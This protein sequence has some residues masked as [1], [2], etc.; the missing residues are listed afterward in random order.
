MS[1]FRESD[2][3][4]FKLK[5]K[6]ICGWVEEVLPDKLVLRSFAQGIRYV[7]EKS[8][9]ERLKP[10]YIGRDEYR[11]LVR[12]ETT[13]YGTDNDNAPENIINKDGYVPTLDDLCYVL[14]KIVQ[15]KKSPNAVKREWLVYFLGAFHVNENVPEDNFFYNYSTVLVK[16]KSD[17]VGWAYS[18]KEIDICAIIDSIEEYQKNRNLP[19]FE[20]QYPEDV[21][22]NLLRRLD[23][24][25]SLNAVD[26]TT[27]KLYKEFAQELCK[28]GNRDGLLAVGYGCYGGNRAFPCDWKKAEECML[29]L[30]ETVD[31]MPARAYYANTLGYIYYYGR[32]NNG[33]PEYE[34]AYK[35]FSYAA[36]NRLIEAEYKIADM[37]QNGYGVQKCL[38]TAKD[39][40]KCLYNTL[41]YKIKD[42]RVGS[43]FADVAL[44]MSRFCAGDCFDENWDYYALLK[45]CYQAE[46]AIRLRRKEFNYY[47][48]DAVQKNIFA[49]LESAKSRSEFKPETK[50][51]CDIKEFFNSFISGE[52]PLDIKPQKMAY[53]KYKLKISSHKKANSHSK[54]LFVTIPELDVCGFYDSITVMLVSSPIDGSDIPDEPFTIDEIDDDAWWDDGSLKALINFGC[55]FEIRKPKENN[56]KYRFVIAQIE[57]DGSSRKCLCDDESIKVGDLVDVLFY[58]HT[59]KATAI[60]VF[61]EADNEICLPL[62]SYY[63]ARKRIE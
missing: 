10:V 53:G 30:F 49:A 2:Y 31:E 27:V 36:F 4:R 42:G 59:P 55:Y 19:V 57:S 50:I 23:D 21:K 20:R 25:D 48:D 44:R 5:R 1:R 62:D 17:L 56:R 40:V 46:F 7:T 47:G 43:D 28:K 52:L 32:C 41:L 34:K 26:E 9:A 54:R 63:K 61:E 22:I 12:Y 14:K 8:K 37:Y 16:A 3:V 35:Y 33:I 58:K 15:D 51:T 11:R 45:Y 29:K 18:T 38:N 39:I 24:N 6:T 60:R 13:I